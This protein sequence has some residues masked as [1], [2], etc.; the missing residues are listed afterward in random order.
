MWLVACRLRHYAHLVLLHQALVGVVLHL[1]HLES[2][3]V[4]LQ[5]ASRQTQSVVGTHPL[6]WPAPVLEQR[7]HLNCYIP[8]HCGLNV[9]SM[10]TAPWLKEQHKSATSR[11]GGCAAG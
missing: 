8:R 4:L 10:V 9:L 1:D 11:R 2:P 7:L 3:I 6:H 5:H